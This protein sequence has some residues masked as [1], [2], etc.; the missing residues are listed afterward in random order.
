M[1]FVVS[2]KT[3][4]TFEKVIYETNLELLR[5]VHTKFLSELD[6]EELKSILDGKKKKKFVIKFEEN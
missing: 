5:E 3:L 2:S 6:F 1:D 4:N